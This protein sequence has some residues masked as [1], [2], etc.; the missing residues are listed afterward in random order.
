MKTAA[1]ESPDKDPKSLKRLVRQLANDFVLL[2]RQE[3]GLLR[4]EIRQ[5]I[6]AHQLVG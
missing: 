4:A 6:L 3:V 5:N 1:E 2:V